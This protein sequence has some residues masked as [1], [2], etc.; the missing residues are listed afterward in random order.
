MTVSTR[1][2]EHRADDPEM[3]RAGEPLL[4]TVVTEAAQRPRRYEPRR[5]ELSASMAAP[6]KAAG[7]IVGAVATRWMRGLFDQLKEVPAAACGGDV[8]R[9]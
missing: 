7:A 1:A 6:R 3:I 8:V 5:R 4:E 2:A 9:A